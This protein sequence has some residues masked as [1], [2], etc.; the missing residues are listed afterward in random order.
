MSNPQGIFWGNCLAQESI[1]G[2][3]VAPQVC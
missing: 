2:V 3:N 1:V